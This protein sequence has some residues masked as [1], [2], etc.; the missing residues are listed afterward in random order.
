[1]ASLPTR[2]EQPTLPKNAATWQSL[3]HR[4]TKCSTRPPCSQW[5]G[6]WHINLL[7]I[8]I[9]RH[10]K[11]PS[12]LFSFHSS[13]KTFLLLWELRNKSKSQCR[14]HA[15]RVVFSQ[16]QLFHLMTTTIYL[17][18]KLSCHPAVTVVSVQQPNWCCLWH[19]FC[20]L[21]DYRINSNKRI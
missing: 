11:Q 2:T 5:E 3:S 9:I 18:Y 8:W 4:Q 16:Q 17:G 6:T 13:V 10:T 15:S 21:V 20:L 7:T 1:M 12:A 14:W 19:G